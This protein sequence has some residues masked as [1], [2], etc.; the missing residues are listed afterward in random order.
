VDALWE[1]EKLADLAALYLNRPQQSLVL[2]LDEKSQ[3]QVTSKRTRRTSFHSVADLKSC[4]ER[5]KEGMT[6]PVISWT[7]RWRF[8]DSS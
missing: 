2:C 8:C 4:L 6:G 1:V 5:E 3:I 7:L